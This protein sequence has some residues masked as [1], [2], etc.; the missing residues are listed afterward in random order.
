[1]KCIFDNNLPPR[2]ARALNELEGPHGIEVIHLRDIFPENIDDITWKNHFSK[3]S[4][5]FEIGRAHV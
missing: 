5:C 1:M 4:D 3:E 2:F